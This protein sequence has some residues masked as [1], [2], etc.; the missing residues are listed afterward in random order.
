MFADEV[1]SVIDYME[2][3]K[4]Y[5]ELVWYLEAC[6]SGSMFPNLRDN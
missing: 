4:Q 6:E 5:N 2:E 1:Q 3:N